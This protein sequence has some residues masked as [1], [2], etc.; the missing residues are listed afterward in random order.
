[1]PYFKDILFSISSACF[2]F[3]RVFFYEVTMSR[4]IS[5]TEGKTTRKHILFFIGL[6]LCFLTFFFSPLCKSGSW[7]QKIKIL[8]TWE[9]CLVEKH[10]TYRKPLLLQSCLRCVVGVFV[11]LGWIKGDFWTF[12]L[13]FSLKTEMRRW[14][15]LTYYWVFQNLV[16]GGDYDSVYQL[17]YI[18]P[19]INL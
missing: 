10:F 11:P 8:Q 12:P 9:T 5:M 15:T 16:R 1:M 14:H 18:F 19:N 7:H 17:W 4:W 13:Y 3:F 2:A 6:V